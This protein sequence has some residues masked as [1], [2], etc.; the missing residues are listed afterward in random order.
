MAGTR[1]RRLGAASGIVWRLRRIDG[2]ALTTDQ[3]P[4]TITR[5]QQWGKRWGEVAEWLKATV[6]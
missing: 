5:L 2:F 3:D 1:A 6:C 4:C